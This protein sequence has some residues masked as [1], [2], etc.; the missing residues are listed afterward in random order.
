M[1]LRNASAAL[2]FMASGTNKR[3]INVCIWINAF[4]MKSLRQILWVSLTE[5]TNER[6]LDT[7]GVEKNLIG[8]I[9]RRMLSGC[10]HVLRKSGDFWKRR[11]S[12]AQF[13]DQKLKEDLKWRGLITQS[14][15]LD[16]K[17]ADYRKRQE[18]EAEGVNRGA[19]NPQIEDNWRQGNRNVAIK[20]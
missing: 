12:K 4:E 16:Y 2:D 13:L 3:C 1:Y 7:A 9:K 20:K 10:R 18:T 8:L 5:R 11:L 14:R 19:I 17:S 15:E 6:E